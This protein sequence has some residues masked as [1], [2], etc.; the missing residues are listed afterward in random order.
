MNNRAK[1]LAM[2]VAALTLLTTSQSLQAQPPGAAKGSPNASTQP[3]SSSQPTGSSPASSSGAGAA[4]Q[5]ISFAKASWDIKLRKLPAPEDLGIRHAKDIRVLCYS[6]VPG[7]SPAQPF[8]LESNP[9]S[10]PL[11]QSKKLYR[12][13][14][15]VMPPQP[16]GHYYRAASTGR[17]DAKPPDFKINGEPTADG[18]NLVW[19]DG[20]STRWAARHTYEYDDLVTPTI[21]N[22]HYFRAHI[23]D[24]NSDSGESGDTQ[25][26]FSG[27]SVRDTGG[28]ISWIDMGDLT[29][30]APAKCDS[31][32]P[33][34]PL[35]MNEILVLAI[36][37]TGIPQ[38]RFE[39]LNLNLT[40]QQGT[41][42]NPT[43]IRPGL[44][45]G[46]ATGPEVSST[47]LEM[48]GG[49]RQRVAQVYYLTWPNQLPGDT[50]V[51]VSVNLVYAPV[52]PALLWIPRTFYPAGSIVISKSS[53]STTNGHY[54]LALNSA[55]SSASPPS[56]N[57][58]AVPVPTFPDGGPAGLT[59]TNRGRTA[60][61]SKPPEWKAG[62]SYAQG[63]QV[64]PPG[65]G[66]GHYYQA[67]TAGKSGP[68]VPAFRTDGNPF[69]DGT[70]STAFQW[71]DMG[72]IT[73]PSWQ[74]NTAYAVGARVV[75]NP[76]NGYWY[77]ATV[78]GVSGPNAPLFANGIG[79]VV[80]E[81]PN[82]LWLDSGP[83]PMP[84][85]IK[86]LKS[87]APQTAFFV[88]DGIFDPSSG[89]YYS[90]I[91]AGISDTTPPPFFIPAP[92][93]VPQSVISEDD[94][95]WQDLGTTLPASV[96]VGIP[97][98][99]QTINL[100][101]YTLPQV[102][103]LSFFNIASGVLVSSIKTP[104]FVNKNTTGSGTPSWTTVYGAPIVDP[105]LALSVYLK[106]MDAER[107]W[108]ASDMIPAPTI[109]FSLTSPASNFYFGGSS[110]FPFV[111][112]LQVVYGFSAAKV[113]VLETA[114][115]QNSN[116]TPVTRQV[117]AKGGFAG[118]SFNILGFIQSV[119]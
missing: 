84:S 111:R 87:W 45:A 85:T 66:N 16:N 96:S 70:G 100:L 118:L 1:L 99:D 47:Y 61:D 65:A 4:L 62:I 15:L 105:I 94:V 6:L 101:T 3:T 33:S 63:A 81:A 40:N 75:T 104:S 69:P 59:W 117:F 9:L 116:T 39:I 113:S 98:S 36:D 20:G 35:L 106:P 31:V 25:P 51:T 119:F 22:G 48:E 97:P 32:S 42:I 29:S 91:Q 102:H 109:G 57:A 24:Q 71:T 56:F 54:Y 110:E 44:T 7:N 78:G 37:A 34:K 82:L 18:S 49:P 58:A 90:V 114:S 86:N 55:I 68:G 8:L 19:E 67:Q 72:F 53:A 95:H 77:E 12:K 23:L 64:V 115:L 2:V 89:H 93:I 46:T 107:R 92:T 50:I 14:D 88:G 38:D 83:A 28:Q 79:G 11:W 60:V 76:P 10:S 30:A 26:D 17:S 103:A 41:P 74:P 112:N 43:P 108:Q 80:M 73:F 21:P 27:N 13:G 52:A 5:G